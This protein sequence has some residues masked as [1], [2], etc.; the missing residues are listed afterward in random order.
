M[1]RK[2]SIKKISRFHFFRLTN[3][4]RYS[5]LI[6]NHEGKIIGGPN[7]PFNEARI[8]ERKLGEVSQSRMILVYNI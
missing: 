4:I 5:K 6:R 8:N 3:E 7:Q 1:K 2:T